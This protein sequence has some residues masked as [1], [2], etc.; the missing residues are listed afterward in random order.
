MFLNSCNNSEKKHKINITDY[1][2]NIPENKNFEDK[3]IIIEFWATWCGPCLSAVPHINKLQEKYK[4][5]KELVFISMT[6]EKAEKVLA[7]LNRIE[8]KTIVVSDQTKKTHRDL[9]VEKNGIM[10]IPLTVL[11]DNK[12]VIKW[13]GLPEDLNEQKIDLFLKGGKLNVNKT[14]INTKN[15]SLKNDFFEK[16]I[17]IIK[18]KKIDT[19]FYLVKAKNENSSMIVNGLTNGKYIVQN[20]KLSN[21]I[22]N[23]TDIPEEQIKI[24]EKFNDLTYNL[25]YKNTTNKEL[26]K[27]LKIK[28]LNRLNLKEKIY[29]K[30]EPV[31]SLKI[32]NKSKLKISRKTEK[33]TGHNSESESHLISS[34]SNINNLI[35][36][37]S[38]TFKIVIVNK[39]GLNENY[40][41][42][43]SKESLEK[44]NIDLRSY[45]LTLEKNMLST[46]IY[47]YE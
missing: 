6:D 1:I 26:P 2:L 45:G 33:N 42:I 17:T 25:I 19:T 21:I 35:R 10:A 11:I 8:F 20:K 13:K 15:I 24:S 7:T 9:E 4:S 16:A 12:G 32:S 44:L 30:E 22:S 38:S 3:Y 39:T 34:G 36:Q 43:L 14:K 37:V 41:L 23:F 27:E 28:I 40:D 18:N 31:Y 29:R 46:K 5:N 47:K